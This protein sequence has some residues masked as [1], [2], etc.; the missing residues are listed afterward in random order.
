MIFYRFQ[1]HRKTINS[2]KLKKENEEY[3]EIFLKK[4][5]YQILIKKFLFNLLSYQ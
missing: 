5:V 3:A 2:R 4:F 1:T